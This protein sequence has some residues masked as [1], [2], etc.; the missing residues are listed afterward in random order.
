MVLPELAFAE[1]T[2]QHAGLDEP[3]LGV[4]ADRAV[5]V[6]HAVVH[7]QVACVFWG[8]PK[9]LLRLEFVVDQTHLLCERGL[10]A[11]HADF[12]C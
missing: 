12:C 9:L 8:R 11:A 5:P 3:V 10:Q 1:P 4:W 6:F 2:G 7:G